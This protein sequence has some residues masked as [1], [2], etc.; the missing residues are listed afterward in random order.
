MPEPVL[1]PVAHEPET[2]GGREFLDALSALANSVVLVTCWAG[3]RSWGM[4]VTAFS[5][6][7]ADPPTVLV[8]L[9]AATTAARAIRRNG[10]FGVGLLG[11]Q[12][13]ALARYGSR[14]GAAKH[15]EGFLDPGAGSRTPVVADAVG[16]LDCEVADMIPAA[17]H[18][19]FIG[20]VRSV[21]AASARRAP[22]LY[23]RRRFRRLGDS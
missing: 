19:L 8:S 18:V 16:H 7:S 20:R 14:P 1:A 5:S 11:H 6:I 2:A 3:G 10:G 23:H 17:D 4:T 15:L 22:L 9:G 13:E 12:Q 21:H